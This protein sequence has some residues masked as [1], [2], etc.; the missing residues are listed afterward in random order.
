M[1]RF[2]RGLAAL[3]VALTPASATLLAAPG[4]APPHPPVGIEAW[5]ADPRRLPDPLTADP[6]AIQR[7]FATLNATKQRELASTYPGV[8][9]NLDGVPIDLRYAAN[10]GQ[11][12]QILLYDPRGDGEVAQVFGDVTTAQRIAILVPGA[13][14]RLAN[15]WRGVGGKAYRSP[16][17]QGADLYQASRAYNK[18]HFAVIVWLGYDAPDG[19]NVAATREDLAED[20]AAA[21]ERFVHG[22]TVIRPQATLALLGYSYGSTVIGLAA[23]HLPV[24]VTD[25]AA[26][27][28]PGMG[29][30]TA[31]GLGTT[32]HVWAGL[33][34]R[35]AMRL[36]PGLKIFGLGHGRQPADPAFGA[37]VFPT[38]DVVDHD[39]YLA[40]G[41]DSLKSLTL[42][43]LFGGEA[44][45]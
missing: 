5:R 20:G 40:P 13:G 26:F 11:E 33:S 45:P 22:L 43:A 30:N 12:R 19:I 8:V 39:H 21:L 27:G 32:A 10:R 14:N 23:R 9:G 4:A 1:R 37:T 18:E 25:L 15:F 2:G 31:A 34:D 16:A 42:I 28:S 38:R 7:Y 41:T 36:V 17:R 24:P 29:V 44:R 3:A 6:A 35:D